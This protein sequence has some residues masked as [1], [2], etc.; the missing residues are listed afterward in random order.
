MAQPRPKFF[1][2]PDE[3]L[4][5]IVEYTGI[6]DPLQKPLS[7][8]EAKTLKDLRL[9]SI[10]FAKLHHLNKKLFRNIV[11][12]AEAHSLNLTT[13]KSYT[14]ITKYVRRVAFWRSVYSGRLPKHAF[15]RFVVSH[16]WG[17]CC[18][19]NGKPNVAVTHADEIEAAWEHYHREG[20]AAEDILASDRLR[21]VWSQVLKDLPNLE[22]VCVAS[23]RFWEYLRSLPS[24]S[25]HQSKVDGCVN[26]FE[27]RLLEDRPAGLTGEEL[28]NPV[29]AALGAVPR[30][31]ITGLELEAD[32]YPEL[33]WEPLWTRITSIM[34]RLTSLTLRERSWQAEYDGELYCAISMSNRRA[35]GLWDQ[36]L[37][38]S[39]PTYAGQLRHLCLDYLHGQT[40]AAFP[41][42]PDLKFP[43]LE[44]L[45]V[46]GVFVDEGKIQGFLHA[47]PNL[48]QFTLRESY[49]GQV[50]VD[51]SAD[52]DDDDG[53][54]VVRPIFDAIRDHP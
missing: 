4:D 18:R 40:C 14:R 24:S 47:S 5:N 10:R 44:H 1:E 38:S 46:A 53:T 26:N 35:E 30:L 9:V 19:A 42:V 31:N 36:V 48:K 37:F 21:D 13:S 6:L 16:H 41:P 51:H 22:T 49:I 54:E 39:L 23:P 34:P 32:C 43:M 3:L 27:R 20:R 52:D 29:L 7:P 33:Q 11:L 25:Y 8:D 15:D 50:G 28:L 2:L 45:D 12:V 17:E